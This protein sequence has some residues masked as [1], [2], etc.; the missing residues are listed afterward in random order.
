MVAEEDFT[1]LVS[2]IP[3]LGAYDLPVPL[4]LVMEGYIIAN[5]E[6]VIKEVLALVEE[7]GMGNVFFLE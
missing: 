4:S 7:S 5:E 6:R 3:R 1:E 2:S